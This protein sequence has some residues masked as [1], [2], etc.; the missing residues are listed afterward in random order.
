MPSDPMASPS[1][2]RRLH[3]LSVLFSLAA[4]ARTLLLPAIFLLF[5]TRSG[6]DGTD[7]WDWQ[8]WMP[9]LL[10]PYAFYAI[11]RYLSFRYRYEESE[12]VIRTGI[13]FR[14][15]R[16]IPYTRIQNVDAVQNVFHRLLGVMEVRVETGGGDEPEAKM[17]VLPVAAYE[18]MRRRVFLEKGMERPAEK[19]KEP[20][21][22]AAPVPLANSTRTLLT[23][24]PREL[25]LC[26]LIQ[27]RGGFILAAAFGLLWEMQIFDRFAPPILRE[28]IPEAE[29]ARGM[30]QELLPTLFGLGETLMSRIALGLLAFAGLLVLLRLVSMVWTLSRLYGFR[31]IAEGED[32]RT[33]YGLFT[34]VTATIPLRRI[35]TLTVRE[36]LLHRLFGRVSVR[37][38]TAGSGASGGEGEGEKTSQREWLAPL[39][40]REALPGLLREVLPEL[41][42]DV[43]EI[44]WQP[45]HP[46]AFAR[47]LKGS[48][49]VAVLA[50]LV[51]ALLLRW[52]AFALLPVLA[53]WAFVYAR[54]SV[55]H[56]G[57][58][59][60]DNVVLFR[61]GWLRREISV[62][63]FA[64]IQAVAVHESPF[65]RRAAMARVRVDTAG[66]KN[67]SHRV[68]IPYLARETARDL[69]DLLAARAARTAFRW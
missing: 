23:L 3:P 14:N 49:F 60:T 5:T 68:D 24:S 63:R 37:V 64:K 26:G 67:A 12:M 33:E 8:F 61:S 7:W 32:L 11:A 10:I 27:N 19:E 35:Q 6:S 41:D 52:W 4:Q 40:R 59:V 62:A 36:G 55:R 13:F 30:I 51:S 16:H 15:E 53:A 66:A 21:D 1:A 42:R 56:L 69:R 34:R 43:S 45:P 39:V 47:E 44:G 58:A 54:Q 9:L 38:D 22:A 28:V 18:D 20:A 29:S 50:A 25:I 31:L 48:L 2:D 65:D 57:W 17:S 46:R